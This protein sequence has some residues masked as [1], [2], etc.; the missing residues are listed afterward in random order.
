MDSVFRLALLAA[1][2]WTPSAKIA[3]VHPFESLYLNVPPAYLNLT[4]VLLITL[5]FL[6]RLE[7]FE[8]PTYGLEVR[9]SIQLSYK[10]INSS[11]S[12]ITN[13]TVMQITNIFGNGIIL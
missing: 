3:S 4:I 10:R 11:K 5:K 12:I 13:K 2:P 8:P 7:G 1:E 9:S 6:V